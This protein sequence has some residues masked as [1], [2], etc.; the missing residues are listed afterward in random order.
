MENHIYV[1]IIQHNSKQFTDQKNF[2]KDTP[3]E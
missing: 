2:L 1:K 3:S